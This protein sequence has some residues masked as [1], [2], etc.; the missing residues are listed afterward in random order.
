MT[1]IKNFLF[2]YLHPSRS[3]PEPTSIFKKILGTMSLLVFNWVL[4]IFFGVVIT[5]LLIEA[6]IMEDPVLKEKAFPTL[7][8]ALIL[9]GLIAPVIEEL[10]SRIWLLYSQRNLSIAIGATISALIYKLCY[11]TGF[12]SASPNIKVGLISIF[13]GVVAGHVTFSTLKKMN[14]NLGEIF[15]KNVLRLA[16]IS[17]IAFGY[18][19]IANYKFT[20]NLLW[21]SP[22]VLAT[23]ITGGLILS[24]VRIRY[25]ILYAMGFHIIHNVI[26]ILIKFR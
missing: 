4:L 20:T 17:S 25:G 23:Y 16:F 21:F 2:F 12:S 10:I 7:I 11:Y 1:S 9:G 22:I 26:F 24:F 13:F 15:R 5:T 14:L 19:H 3:S 18:L 6:G 8:T